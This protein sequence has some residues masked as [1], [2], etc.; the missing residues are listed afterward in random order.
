MPE[1]GLLRV[2]ASERCGRLGEGP[3]DLGLNKREHLAKS[4][5]SCPM[6]GKT[7]ANA[8]SDNAANPG[9]AVKSATMSNAANVNA[10]AAPKTLDL[11]EGDQVDAL[12]GRKVITVF[13]NA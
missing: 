10:S 5:F 13:R 8:P 3:L 7:M 1:S 12:F 6:L 11:V 9:D 2:M 4:A